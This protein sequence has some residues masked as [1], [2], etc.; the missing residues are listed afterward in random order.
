M[1]IDWM[2]VFLVSVWLAVFGL[3]LTGHVRCHVL[4]KP[5]ECPY[6]Y[7]SPR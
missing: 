3:I 1:K 4:D 6:V 7:S 2:F 5:N